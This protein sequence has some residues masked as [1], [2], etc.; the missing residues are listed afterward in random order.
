MERIDTKEMTLIVR[1][2]KDNNLEMF[3][4]FYDLTKKQVYF[5]IM[6]ILKNRES[7][8][9]IMQDTYMRF[10]NNIDKYKES[11]NVIAFLVTI[12]RNLAINLY[13][14]NKKEIKYDF[15]RYEDTYVNDTKDNS[16]MEVVYETLEGDELEVF[17]L[18]VIDDLKHREI[19]KIM[20]KPLGTITWMY[21]KAV[22]KLKMK[23]GEQDE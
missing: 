10:L 20:K 5:A 21:N 1:S 22:K 7:T 3:D 4:R 8:E 6:S 17:I 14:R 13:N 19:A 23:V 11:T 9:D 15:S 18:H 12:A 2:L 16:L